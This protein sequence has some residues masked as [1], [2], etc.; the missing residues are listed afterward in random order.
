MLG[1]KVGHKVISCGR[2]SAGRR[3]GPAIARTV[4]PNH[5]GIA[6]YSGANAVKPGMGIYRM[7]G[8]RIS[9]DE[10]KTWRRIARPRGTLPGSGTFP[11]P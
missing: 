10:G 9:S 1:L 8:E 3:T 11:L 5:F 2:S 4:V 7:M 6:V